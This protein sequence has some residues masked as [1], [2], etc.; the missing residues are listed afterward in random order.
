MVVVSRTVDS[1]EGA[2]PAREGRQYNPGA[3]LG[4]VVASPGRNAPGQHIGGLHAS[5]GREDTSMEREIRS[6]ERRRMCR[7]SAS[8]VPVLNEVSSLA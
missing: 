5:A 7:G 4:I 8:R 2:V 1:V 6:K 3:L